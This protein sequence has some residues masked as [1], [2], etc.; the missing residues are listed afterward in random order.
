MKKILIIIVAIILYIALIAAAYI[1]LANLAHLLGWAF[2][3]TIALIICITLIIDS[4]R[5]KDE[6]KN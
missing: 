2:S 4:L 6:D 5:N 1:F 3:L